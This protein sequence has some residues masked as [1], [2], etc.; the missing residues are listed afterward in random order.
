MEMF[1]NLLAKAKSLISNLL[2]WMTPFSWL[3]TLAFAFGFF[4]GSE[5]EWEGTIFFTFFWIVGMFIWHQ[6]DKMRS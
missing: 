2:P 6:Y 4:A 3:G 1:K 5:G